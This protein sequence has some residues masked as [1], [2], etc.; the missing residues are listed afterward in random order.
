M[1][2]VLI[3]ELEINEDNLSR[4]NN[5]F[6]IAG[7]VSATNTLIGVYAL[8]DR[9]PLPVFVGKYDAKN[10]RDFNDQVLLDSL[11][12]AGVN[13]DDVESAVFSP[14]G[15]ISTDRRTCDLTNAKF[16]I[17]AAT[18]NI[19]SVAI[20]NDY[21]A[22]AYAVLSFGLKGDLEHL[23]L[24]HSFKGSDGKEYFGERVENETIAIHGAGTGFGT[25]RIFWDR[26]NGEYRVENI[27]PRRSEGGH[28]MIPVTTHEEVDLVDWLKDYK[29]DGFNPPL[30][31]ILSGQGID[32]VFE[33]LIRRS[34]NNFMRIPKKVKDP[35]VYIADQA[36]RNPNTEFAQTMDLFWTIY[37]RALH[38]L[39]V[40]E[41]A[42]GGVWVSGG[43]IMGE[44][45][46]NPGT[47]V[48]DKRIARRIMSEFDSG[49]THRDWYLKI[50]VSAIM[51]R[52]VGLKGA[53]EVASKPAYL[54]REKY[55]PQAA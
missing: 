34:G 25:A 44:I 8:S 47:G 9:G 41:V 46:Y 33:Y 4:A 22:I 1:S 17:D 55:V 2:S 29:Y 48:V 14:A 50:P 7:D 31:A 28:R 35:A 15:D 16:N 32:D 26:E 18:M 11:K 21:T 38:D 12:R 54:E 13:I 3:K 45:E 10:V 23:V 6:C 20:I 27:R 52:L 43:I 19:P 37:G 51:D 49:A 30:E 36:R 24:P 5:G 39:A 53:L 42:K 40:H